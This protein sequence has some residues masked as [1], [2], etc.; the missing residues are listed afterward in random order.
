MMN[1]TRARSLA[2]AIAL[3]LGV[4][5]CEIAPPKEPQDAP[6]DAPT[7]KPSDEPA[8][9]G[10]QGEEGNSIMRP[11]VEA[12]REAEKELEPLEVTIGFPDGGSELSEGAEAAIAELL[13][14]EEVKRGGSITIG[15]HSDSD[16]TDDANLRASQRR[17][18][19]VAA[20]LVEGGVD[21][22]RITVIA[23]GEQNPVKPNALPDGSPN[24]AG[25]AANR[26]VDIRVAPPKNPAPPKE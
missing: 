8:G 12:E 24:E 11:E 13:A 23:F 4:A 18:D 14:S 7:T 1:A 25:R 10:P 22:A 5:A 9:F 17:A 20:K 2:L 16:G 3:S 26:R 21:E 15:G 6:T 19:A